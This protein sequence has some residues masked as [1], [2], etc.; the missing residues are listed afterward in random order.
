MIGE[1]KLTQPHLSMET[2]EHRWI[3]DAAIRLA[4]KL[5]RKRAACDTGFGITEALGAVII[6]HVLSELLSICT[7]A[8]GDKVSGRRGRKRKL[9][10]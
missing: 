7:I 9:F 4:S 2:R 5:R 10:T 6:L 1:R 8:G 3:D